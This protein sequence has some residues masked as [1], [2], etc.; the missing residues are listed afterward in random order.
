MI[1]VTRT[2]DYGAQVELVGS[3][4]DDAFAACLEH[5]K[6]GDGGVLVHP[7]DDPVVISG[8]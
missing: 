4:Y 1:K 8:T 2:K 5:S 3:N 6:Q 7:F